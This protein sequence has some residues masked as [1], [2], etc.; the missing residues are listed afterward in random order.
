MP[1]TLP[2]DYYE[3]SSNHG[4]YVYRTLEEIVYNF[5]QGYT[6]DNTI[7]GHVERRNVLFWAKLGLK[8]FTI[9]AL[10]EVKAV[11]LEL[12]DTLDIILPP[13]Y[14]SYVRVCYVNQKTGELMPLAR[15]LS[16]P[17][18][19]A[20]LQDHNAEILFDN[21]GYILE[22]T[23]AFQELNDMIASGQL[24]GNLEAISQQIGDIAIDF[25]R[26]GEIIRDAYAGLSDDTKN[27]LTS[28][29]TEMPQNIRAFVQLTVTELLV[30][31][32]KAAA[33]GNLM[34]ES[35]NPAKAFSG[36]AMAGFRTEMQRINSV[37]DDSIAAILREKD[38]ATDLANT[39]RERAKLAREFYDWNKENSKNA[40]DS[41]GQYKVK[42][43]EVVA[44]TKEA[45]AAAKKLAE[46]AK[47]AEETRL[48]GIAA[49]VIGL[50]KN[51]KRHLLILISRL[52]HP[53]LF[54]N[55][56]MTEGQ[57]R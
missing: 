44:I 34:R 5:I 12:G 54:R 55:L 47:R 16:M 35:L 17:L 52:N 41:L 49:V 42:S 43:Q 15:D 24:Q 1:T 20:Y 50:Q 45:I 6:G 38:A 23:T 22:G 33:I 53:S 2:I 14:L 31:S 28:A 19:T 30:L 25:S 57:M 13:D 10:R 56:V 7:I 32:E 18:A 3:E 48:G 39:T 36:D 29:F 51:Q 46:E 9:D 37:R 11:E 26:A 40:G 4:N 21:D 8:E 27:V